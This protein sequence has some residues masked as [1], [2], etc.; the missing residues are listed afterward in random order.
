VIA[1]EPAV[2]TGT[3]SSTSVDQDAPSPIALMDNDQYFGLPIPEPSSEESSSQVVIPNSVHFVNQPPEH[4]SKWTKDHPIDNVIGDPSKPVSTR[5]QIQNEAIFCY[6]DAF[7]SSV[8]PKS[9]KEAL[10]E[11]CWIEAMQEELNEFERLEVWELAR[12][13]ARGYRQKEGIDFEECFVPV[14]QLEA[15]CLR[16]STGWVLYPENPNH[17]YKLKKALYGLK[18]APRAWYDLLS[19]YLLS[20]NFSKGAVDPTLFIRWEGKDILQILPWLKKFPQ[21]DEDPQRNAVI[22]TRY[23]DSCMSLTALADAAQHKVPRN[24]RRSTIWNSNTLDAIT[25]DRPMVLIPI[26]SLCIAIN[27]EV[28][29]PYAVTTSNTPN[30]SILTSDI[31]S[32]RSKWKMGWLNSTSS[33][34]NISWQISLPRHWDENDLTF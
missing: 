10:T 21:N 13:V 3:P 18:Q 2:S 19:S 4:V 7:L 8:E 22:P 26:K 5:H 6:F 17:V 24:T 31:T 9:Y 16:Q 11:S 23:P 15:I 33:K 1:L 27:K 12:L 14:A 25:T 32:S 20:K 29:M 34:Q 30:Q 28:P